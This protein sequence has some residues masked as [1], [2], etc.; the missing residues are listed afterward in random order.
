MGLLCCY[1]STI[2]YQNK[3]KQYK[4]LVERFRFENFT[5]DELNHINYF[6]ITDERRGIHF[7]V[8]RGTHVENLKQ[9]IS[10]LFI[11]LNFR[12]KT[13][14]NYKIHNGYYK[15]GETMLE[16]L[17]FHIKE[18][19]DDGYRIV[20]TGHSLGGAISKYMSVKCDVDCESY[21]YGSPII[22]TDAFYEQTNYN[23]QQNDYI[24]DG[25]LIPNFPS[26]IVSNLNCYKI[27]KDHIKQTN[28]ENKHFIQ[29][30]FYL[31]EFKLLFCRR[32]LSKTHG[33]N[34]YLYYL[35]KNVKK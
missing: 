15:C 26:S 19:Y 13:I 12:L 9:R 32:M 31:L 34:Y 23:V 1:L 24:N 10:T 25:D 8:F 14:S 35:K 22:A 27:H 30:L 4:W 11:S 28:K 16:H 7:I 20:F 21:T 17:Y 2:A 3:A 18:K 6:M 33:M 29:S 5:S